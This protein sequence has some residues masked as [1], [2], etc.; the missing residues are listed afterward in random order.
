MKT[1]LFF[2]IV[3]IALT[4]ILDTISQLFLKSSINKLDFHINNLKKIFRFIG[5][6]ILIPW[7]WLSGIFSILSLSIWLFVLSKADLNFAFSIDS[8]HYILVAF[9]SGLVL[10]ER[11]DGIRWLGTI[12]IVIGIFIVTVS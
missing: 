4:G 12:F 8:I 5:H 9:G 10:K 2:I 3:L 6:L 7:V 11:V 1:N